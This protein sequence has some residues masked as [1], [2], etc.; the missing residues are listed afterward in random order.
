[1]HDWESSHGSRQSCTIGLMPIFTLPVGP[2]AVKDFGGLVQPEAGR[3]GEG[4]GD[5]EGGPRPPYFQRRADP[6]RISF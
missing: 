6:A 5:Q 2:S 4:R 3:A 1:M